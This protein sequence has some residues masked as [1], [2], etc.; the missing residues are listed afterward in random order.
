MRGPPEVLYFLPTPSCL[1]T[2]CCVDQ[3]FVG[4]VTIPGHLGDFGWRQQ[5][6]SLQ[7]H[8]WQQSSTPWPLR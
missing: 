3:G 2:T 7:I 8:L 1:L 4:H 5:L 6:S